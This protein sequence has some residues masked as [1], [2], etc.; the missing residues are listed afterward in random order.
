MIPSRRSS[1]AGSV[2]RLALAA[3]CLGAAAAG[4]SAIFVRLSELGPLPSAFY[5]PFLA[6]PMLLLWLRF[7]PGGGNKRRPATRREYGELLLAG[8]FFG[9]DLAFWHLALHNTTVANATLFANAAPIFVVIGG[10]LIFGRRVTR[11]FLAGM[12]LALIGAAFLVGGSLAIRPDNLV[13]DGFGVVTAMFLAAYLMAVERLRTI[14]SAA[15]I[16]TWT[17]IGTAAVLLPVALLAGEPMIARTAFGW[18]MLL[19]LAGISHVAGQGLIAYALAHLPVSFIA[20]GLLLEPVAAAALALAVLD[21]VPNLWQ[22]AGGAIVLWGVTVARRGSAPPCP[23]REKG[24]QCVAG[25]PVD[26]KDG[27]T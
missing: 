5:R 19:A 1:A 20:V 26:R 7:A 10:R 14:F 22:A 8:A 15:T 6:V 27:D 23:H 9:G 17:S 3:L 4:A 12:F 13:G 11:T 24:S 2:E 18:A 25:R 21:E 16:M